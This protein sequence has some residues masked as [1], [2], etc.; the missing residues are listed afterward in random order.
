LFE[1]EGEMILGLGWFIYL[2]I[3]MCWLF[4]EILYYIIIKK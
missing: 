3:F 1:V 4:D 2:D